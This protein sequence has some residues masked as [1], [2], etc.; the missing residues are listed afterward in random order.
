MVALVV[1]VVVVL[2]PEIALVLGLVPALVLVPEHLTSAHA[3]SCTC[4]RF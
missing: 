3:C 4:W 1:L 2:V